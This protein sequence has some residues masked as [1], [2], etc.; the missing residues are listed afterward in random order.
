LVT[1]RF[2]PTWSGRGQQIGCA[3]DSQ[4]VRQSHPARAKRWFAK[5]GELMDDR[6]R[7]QADHRAQQAIAIQCV[8]DDRL[9]T[10][11]AH[12]GGTG[13]IADQPEHAVASGDQ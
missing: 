5:S 2:A 12:T 9:R 6:I 10:E 7:C 11:R 3:F 4:A 1:I 8:G 13:R